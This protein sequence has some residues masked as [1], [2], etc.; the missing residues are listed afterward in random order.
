MAM[1]C[2]LCFAVIEK[3]KAGAPGN[4]VRTAGRD[5][6]QILHEEVGER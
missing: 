5:G 1:E 4:G 6:K 2:I 3:L